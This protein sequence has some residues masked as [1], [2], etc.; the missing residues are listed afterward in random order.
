[1]KMKGCDR[2]LRWR[3]KEDGRFR[4]NMKTGEEYKQEDR[5]KTFSWKK[6]MM[7]D[8]DRR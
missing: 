1:M 8:E 3:I 2:R 7:G 6:M 4:Q 5:R